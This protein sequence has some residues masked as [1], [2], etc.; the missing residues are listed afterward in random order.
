MKRIAVALLIAACGGSSK[1]ART[2]T[3]SEP[4][5]P[6]AAPATPAP[7]T[8]PP[9]PVAAKPE[10]LT[11]DT[12][13]STTNA[14]FVAPAG[15]SIATHDSA[16]VLTPPEAGSYIA[17]VDVAGKDADAAVAAAWAAHDPTG[18]GA[19]QR[20]VDAAPRL[21]WDQARE[22]AYET[23][24]AQH[25]SVSATAYRHGDAWTVALYSMEQAVEQKRS[26]A[27]GTI[28]DRLEARGYQRESFAGKQAHVLDAARVDA[29]KKF[30]ATAQ[31]QLGVPGVAIGLVQDGKVV[32]AGGFGVRELGKKAPVDAD[33]LFIIASNT[34]AMTT[35][36]LATLVDDKK[37]GW[38]T[39][40]TQLDPSFVLGDAE[41]TRQVL[42]KHLVCACTGLPRQDLEWLFEFA[43]ATPLT[44]LHTLAGVQPTSKFGEMYQ[45]SNLLAAAAGF[46]AAHVLSPGKELGAAYDEAMQRRVFGPLHM[47]STTFDFARA[48]RADHAGGHAFDIDGK[49]AVAPMAINYAVVPLRPAGG[50]WSNVNDM[51]RYV[52]L[53]LGNGVLDGKRVV[54]EEALLARRAP[55]VS[56]GNDVTYGMGL[57]VDRTWGIPV[58]HHG[59]SMIGFKTDMIWLP[60]QGVGAVILT[61]ADSGRQMEEPF[62]RRLLEVLFDGKPEAE[63]DVA[64]EAASLRAAIAGERARLTVPAEPAQAAALAA[65]Y[66]ND[67]LG[68]IDVKTDGKRTIFDFGEFASEV[69]T[70]KNDDGTRSFETIVPGFDG[71]QLIAG[72]KDGKRTLT[73]LDAQHSYVFTEAAR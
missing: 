41:T 64:S 66:R 11:V 51:L 22:Y 57:E 19:L 50:A 14:S 20:A 34:K 15:W 43:H 37:L 7:T 70:R 62:R 35:L 36:L 63:G 48:L 16:T 10:L 12:P 30:V 65:H 60:E 73:L 52:Q 55:Q 4:A 53:E 71:F 6:A 69:A 45:Y 26:A 46:V 33:T 31:E 13:R 17:L 58:V 2:V 28:F 24:A 18:H 44:E 27:V 3:T 61:N 40:V 56:N 38:E 72:T 23:S 25:R 42:V 68:A 21:G 1:P 8:P 67:A 5:P 59:G 49:T 32:F 54:S 29:L 9:T 39:P 47:T